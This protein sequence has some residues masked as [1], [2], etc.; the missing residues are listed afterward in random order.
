V[1][2]A[3][4]IE[5]VDAAPRGLEQLDK[6]RAPILRTADRSDIALV[7]GSN[8]HGW[9][10]TAAAWSVMS[11]PGWRAKDAGGLESAILLRL[12]MGRRSEVQVVERRRVM[13]R[14]WV[15]TLLTAPDLAAT[16]ARTLSPAERAAWLAWIWV[17]LG[18]VSFSWRRVRR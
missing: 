9:G 6:S 17:S 8:N 4:G 11:I 16:I 7:S 2:D 14:S 18:L 15:L 1:F 10:R 12:T 13:A 3:R 5:L